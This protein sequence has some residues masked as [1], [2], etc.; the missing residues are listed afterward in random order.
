MKK[1]IKEFFSYTLHKFS[2]IEVQRIKLRSGWVFQLAS[3]I[4]IYKRTIVNPSKHQELTNLLLEGPIK[5]EGIPSVCKVFTQ[6]PL[7][8][9]NYLYKLDKAVLVGNY[10]LIYKDG[11]YLRESVFFSEEHDRLGSQVRSNF[12]SRFKHNLSL[13]PRPKDKKS[14]SN[15]MLLFSKWN[16]YGHWVPEH[17]LKLKILF[18]ALGEDALDVCLIIENNPP[19]WKIKILNALGWDSKKIVEWDSCREYVEDLYCPSYPSPNYDAFLWLKKRLAQGLDLDVKKNARRKLYLSRNKFG[20]R[21]VKN[22]SELITFLSG[23]GFEV[24]YPEEMTLE[25]QILAFLE[26]EVV[27]GPHGSALTNLIFSND[28]KV[29]EFFGEFVP[30]G[31]YCYSKVM[32]HNYSP[33]FC[34][35]GCNKNDYLIVDIG[36]LNRLL[37]S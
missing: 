12:V 13:S 14:I 36:K 5:P 3:S 7:A 19:A 35:S 23:K 20:S 32:G 26:A 2:Q 15:C 30:L 27:V 29:I 31:F 33:L 34:E 4:C 17:L 8:S 18:D 25:H 9:N 10:P 24:L 28:I 11:L 37:S 16:H 1:I 6:A 21:G 22:E